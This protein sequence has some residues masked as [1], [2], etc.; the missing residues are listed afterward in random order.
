MPRYIDVDKIGY[1][2]NPECEGKCDKCRKDDRIV[3]EESIEQ[4]PI[5]DVQEVK[6][7]KWIFLGS[8]KA[9]C[10]NCNR[11]FADVYDMDNY[12]NHCRHCG[13]RMD[14]DEK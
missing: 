3:S 13:A 2:C 14:G 4:I 12:D 8:G 10:S 9:T 7:G 11:T 6:H 1:F 5:A